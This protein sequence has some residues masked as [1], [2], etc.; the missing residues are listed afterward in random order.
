MTPDQRV[1]AFSLKAL[2]FHVPMV[3]GVV[4]CVFAGWFELSRAR[5][6]HTIAW[7]YACEWPGFAIVGI[8]IWWRIISNADER[9]ISD[10]A[11]TSR[12][13]PLISPDDPGLMAWR[14]YLA[15][16]QQSERASG[17]D[18]AD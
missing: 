4:G 2:R 3:V 6:G 12:R 10:G 9:K 8:Y 17:A 15:D 13:Q 14:Q 16:A 5:E 11:P 7:V 1:N 18:T